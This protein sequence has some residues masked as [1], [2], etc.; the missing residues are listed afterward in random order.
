MVGALIVRAATSIASDK[1]RHLNDIILG[2]DDEA[3]GRMQI[4]RQN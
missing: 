4:L 3:I 1:A 2:Q